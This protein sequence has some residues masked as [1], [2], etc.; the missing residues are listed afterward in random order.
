MKT[1]AGKRLRMISFRVDDEVLGA[2]E[3]LEAAVGSSVVSKSKRSIAIR[4][5]LLEARDRLSR[6]AKKSV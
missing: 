6:S 5:A 3:E 2:L 1:D 4:K